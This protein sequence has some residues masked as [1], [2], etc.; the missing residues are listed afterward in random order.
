MMEELGS[1]PHNMSNSSPVI[2]GDLIFVSTSNGHDE[3]HVTLPSPRAPAIIAVNKKTGELVWEDN[4]VGE[5]MS[6]TDNGRRPPWERSAV[7]FRSSWARATDGFGATWPR[8]ARSSGSSTPTPRTPCGRTNRN[9]VISTPVIYNDKVYIANGQDPEHGEGVGHFYAIDGTKRGRHHRERPSL[10]LR[11][12]SPVDLDSRPSRTV[13]STCPT[14]AASSTPRRRDREV[15]WVHDTFAAV[16]GSPLI[17]DG[18]VYLGD[19]DGDVVVLKPGKEEVVLAEMN[20]GSSVYSS[21][22]ARQR[23]ALHRQPQPALRPGS[24]KLD[25][26]CG[27]IAV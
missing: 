25:P 21:P 26:F 15:Q 2:Y 27:C 7:S 23:R 4:S 10:A 8:P 5:N 19:E 9:N 24:K 11:Q 1:F 16:W 13:S 14:S 20:M 6:F 18:K 22:V 17:A 12:D 3:S